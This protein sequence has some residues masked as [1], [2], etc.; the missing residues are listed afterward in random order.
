M[1]Q[2]KARIALKQKAVKDYNKLMEDWEKLQEENVQAQ[3][4]SAL[5][6]L[7]GSV[8]LPLISNFIF[9]G[10]SVLGG[11]VASGV[12]SYVGGKA[13]EKQ[14]GRLIDF[15]FGGEGVQGG[16]AISPVGLR[17]DAR[18]SIQSQA[19]LAY[20]S[21]DED[22]TAKAFSDFI[23]SYANVGG[24]INN[25]NLGDPYKPTLFKMLQG[26]K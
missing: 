5:G 21:F 2:A 18:R 3:S 26:N 8:A 24:D 20:G 9:P 1:S 22:L 4:K 14:R 19:D 7:F 10:M 11:M 17:A 12:G 13:G 25:I 6:S 23:Y 16:E 15:D